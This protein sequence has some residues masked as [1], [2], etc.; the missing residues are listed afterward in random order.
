MAAGFCE[1]VFESLKLLEGRD[2]CELVLAEAA[3]EFVV[4]EENFSLLNARVAADEAG[5]GDG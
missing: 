2:D 5:E 4:I 1:V 3:G